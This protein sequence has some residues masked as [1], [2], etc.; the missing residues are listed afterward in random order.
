MHQFFFILVM[1]LNICLFQTGRDCDVQIECVRVVNSS[2]RVLS[3]HGASQK[4]IYG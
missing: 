4:Y 1:L 2:M 3:P